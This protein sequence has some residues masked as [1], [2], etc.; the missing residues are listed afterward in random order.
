MLREGI[1]TDTQRLPKVLDPCCTAG[2]TRTED[3]AD[4]LSCLPWTRARRW[5]FRP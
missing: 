3:D 5:R 1:E 2:Y 4:S